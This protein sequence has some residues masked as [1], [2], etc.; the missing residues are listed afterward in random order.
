MQVR[1]FVLTVL[2]AVFMSFS[3]G[4]G[5]GVGTSGTPFVLEAKGTPLGDFTL[6]G[7]SNSE[8]P[9]DSIKKLLFDSQSLN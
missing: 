7:D 5:I 1:K 3:I 8:L 4:L 6:R 9:S 2:I